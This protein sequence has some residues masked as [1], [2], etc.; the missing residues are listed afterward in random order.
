MT[1]Q[2]QKWMNVDISCLKCLW[3]SLVYRSFI[4]I[5]RET[6]QENKYIDLHVSEWKYLILKHD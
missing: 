6:E 3:F 2:L 1:A 5:E 4:L